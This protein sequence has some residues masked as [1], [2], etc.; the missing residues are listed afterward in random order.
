MSDIVIVGM[1]SF[2]GTGI[3]TFG[4]IL[5][6]NKLTNYRIQQLEERVDEHNKVVDRTYTLEKL[7]GITDKEIDVINHR[8]KDLEGGA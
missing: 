3:A 5:V 1:L 2:L 8:L 7:Q 6:S 4:G